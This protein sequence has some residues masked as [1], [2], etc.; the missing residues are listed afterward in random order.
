[1]S[2]GPPVPF[3]RQ[4]LPILA[5]LGILVFGLIVQ[6]LVLGQPSSTL[7][8]VFL[9]A[10]A[11]SIA[12]LSFLGY[13]WETIQNAMVTRVT[14][15]LPAIFILFAIG[16]LIGSWVTAGI[17]PMLVYHGVNMIDPQYLYLCAFIIPA[18]FSTLTGTSWGSAGTIGVVILGI[19]QVLGADL[20]LTAGAVV[21][22]SYFGDKL[23][24]LS[25]TTNIAALATEVDL[26]DHVR[27]QMWTT[28]PASALACIAYTIIGFA[29]DPSANEINSESVD[30][31]LTALADS[32]TFS[33]VLLLPIGV[34]LWG[35]IKRKPTAPT[36]IVSA[37]LAVG[38]ALIYQPFPSGAI[39][40]SLISG[41][42]PDMI[43][44][45]SEPLPPSVVTL[46]DRG[47]LYNLI[48]GIVVA[49]L[50]FAFVGTLE[51]VHALEAV[52][53]RVLVFAVKRPITIVTALL[54]ST[55]TN[56]LTSNQFATSFLVGTAFGK[57]FDE[58]GIP[59][60]VL[61]RCLEDG[62]TMMEN[63]LPWTATGVYMTTALGVS[64][65]DY[66]PWQLLAWF[67]YALAF[68][69]AFTG[70]ACFYKKTA[71]SKP[72]ST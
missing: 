7:E 62:G 32:F 42:D 52:T 17:I 71:S 53:Q 36:L 22:G 56:A 20:A 16:V 30:A 72:L 48:S 34:V 49:I 68:I 12:N 69:F 28:L 18:I 4:I 43:G 61:S 45:R 23:S 15:A 39:L 41:F 38:I 21:G 14:Q 46:L 59:R 64:P 44:G 60:R 58:L 33:P 50:V 10:L 47:G 11:V 54:S 27:S 5:L 2:D 66:A 65:L 35:S 8:L 67:N 1:M 51:V 9:L 3:A 25:D 37:I 55:A 29:S 63:L 26:F 70:F 57:R 40:E 24:P 31:T 13:E 6:P 19:A